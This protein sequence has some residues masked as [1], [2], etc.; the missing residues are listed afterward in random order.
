M[1]Q[2][3]QLVDAANK[4]NPEELAFLIKIMQLVDADPTKSEAR[5]T[6]AEQRASMYRLRTE[7]GRNSFLEALQAV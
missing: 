4:L 3:R 5:A 2:N 7:E 6:F 1:K